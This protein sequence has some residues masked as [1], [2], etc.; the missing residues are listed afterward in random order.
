[1]GLLDRFK[2]EK[3]SYCGKEVAKIKLVKYSDF[4]F[5]SEDCICK[6]FRDMTTEE[7]IEHY[8]KDR[9]ITT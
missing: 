1:M 4:Y 7:V 6:A 3:C 8:K 2:K 5:C 9:G